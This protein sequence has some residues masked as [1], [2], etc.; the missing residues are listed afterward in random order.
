MKDNYKDITIFSTINE[1]MNRHIAWSTDNPIQ[2]ELNRPYILDGLLVSLIEYGES[3]LM[4]NF[5]EY[6]TTSNSVLVIGSQ[7]ILEVLHTDTDRNVR[8]FFIPPDMLIEQEVFSGYEIFFEL[9]QYPYFRV[10]DS[11]MRELIRFHD[12]IVDQ[13]HLVVESCQKEF[14]KYLVNALSVKI[15]SIYREIDLSDH[16]G[17]IKTNNEVVVSNFY[18]LLFNH[19]KEERE[20]TFYADKLC[21]SPKHLSFVVKQVLGKP[22]SYWITHMLV[23]NVKYQLKTTTLN[24]NEI[25]DDFNF[26]SPSVFGRF[27]KKNTGMTPVQYRDS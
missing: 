10:S 22:I 2:Y 18:K 20:V 9:S 3:K 19:Y 1:D 21:I 11:K 8:A 17:T 15:K 25:A 14:D 6:T 5:K 7:S 23:S 13:Q 26:A 12:F 16:V 4:I 27:F 24:V